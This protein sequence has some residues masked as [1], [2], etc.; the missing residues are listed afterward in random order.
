MAAW[1]TKNRSRAT[2]F[3]RFFSATFGAGV[4]ATQHPI[5]CP[6]RQLQPKRYA[7]FFK[8]IF[9][10][11]IDKIFK[12]TYIHRMKKLPIFFVTVFCIILLYSCRSFW[13]IVEIA[14]MDEK[15][16]AFIKF[17]EINKKVYIQTHI[18]GISM[19]NFYIFISSRKKNE[20]DDNHIDIINRDN[21]LL[22]NY[23]PDEIIKLPF[24]TDLVFN[25]RMEIYYKKIEPDNLFI[26]V[27][28]F[29][30]I[31]K[32]YTKINGINIFI[33]FVSDYRFDKNEKIKSYRENGY[34]KIYVYDGIEK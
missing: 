18:W 5:T 4:V 25:D 17:K 27:P 13:Y 21:P 28:E 12:I 10:I 2:P 6:K 7:T 26:F 22:I 14:N 31:G 16:S 11:T 9:K 3:V 29:R 32:L 8:I 15:H 23:L 24:D 19:N 30:K 33:D 20:P 34:K 1:A